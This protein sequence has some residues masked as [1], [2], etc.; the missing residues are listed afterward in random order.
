MDQKILN[1]NEDQ[2]RKSGFGEAFTADLKEQMEQ[3]FPLI[4]NK[5]QRG[6][7]GNLLE[8][9]LYLKKSSISAYYSLKKFDLKL[10]KEGLGDTL[11]HTFN[12]TDTNFG[13]AQINANTV[14]AFR[15]NVLT[16]MP[17][18]P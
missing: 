12:I 3:Q 16:R 4:I 13:T 5:F 8:A 1:F 14:L 7:D 6:H 9:T 17:Y 10:Q 15:T 18:S 2:L 11:K